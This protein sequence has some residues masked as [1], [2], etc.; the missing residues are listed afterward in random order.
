[1]STLGRR[2]SRLTRGCP[3][4]D[5]ATETR[6]VASRPHRSP[7]HSCPGGRSSLSGRC[8]PCRPHPSTSCSCSPQ[9]AYVRRR[10]ASLLSRRAAR[11]R[12]VAHLASDLPSRVWP[13]RSPRTSAPAGGRSRWSWPRLRVEATWRGSLLTSGWGDTTWDDSSSNPQNVVKG[14]RKRTPCDLDRQV[15]PVYRNC[16]SDA[17][18]AALSERYDKADR[19]DSGREGSWRTQNAQRLS[20]TRPS[21]CLTP[22]PRMTRTELERR[23]AKRSA[24]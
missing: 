18:I 16:A 13:A 5:R 15:D 2:P 11:P 14:G 22:R 3:Y 8:A 6:R 9:D 20:R 21:S 12:S 24:S 4:R 19:V 17:L 23:I 1:M 10:A 7:A